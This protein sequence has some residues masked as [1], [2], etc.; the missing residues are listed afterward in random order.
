MDREGVVFTADD[1]EVGEED[2][3]IQRTGSL[4]DSAA[5]S[6]LQLAVYDYWSHLETEIFVARPNHFIIGEAVARL[7]DG[8]VNV[9]AGYL[10][11]LRAVAALGIVGVEAGN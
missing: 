4:A 8:A 1:F 6:R 3:V 10:D 11:V 9:L 5:H 2:R 7:Q